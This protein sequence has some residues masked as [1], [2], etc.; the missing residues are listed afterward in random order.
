VEIRPVRR[1]D[2][3]PLADT[4][5]AAF[6]V[7]PFSR[8]LF[9][10]DDLHD[11]L[12]KSFEIQL[13][14]ISMPKKE[15]FTT[16][17]LAGAALWAPPGQWKLSSWQELRLAPSYLHALGPRRVAKAAPAARM[18]ERAHPFEPHWHLAVLGVAP[19]R[20][21]TGVGSALLRPMLER[22][23]ADGVLAYL[24]TARPENIAYYERHGFTV[25]KQLEVPHGG[26]P[27]WTMTR[28]P[29]R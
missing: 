9:G 16:D 21:R 1:S 19:D 5:A 28:R 23:D 13:R 14:I 25:S 27:M 26:P 15:S 20:Q 24:E 3:A 8:W 22:A 11:R 29:M 7:D 6:E 2:I 10:P 17:D 12:R 4:L 18:I